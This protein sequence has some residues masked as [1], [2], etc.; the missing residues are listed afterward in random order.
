MLRLTHTQQTLMK[1]PPSVIHDLNL[2]AFASACRF[3]FP[4]DEQSGEERR[5]CE[6]S[7]D[8][9]PAP[10]ATFPSAAAS[11][12]LPTSLCPSRPH[13]VP[14][15]ATPSSSPPQTAELLCQAAKMLGHSMENI[16]KEKH[17]LSLTTKLW[18]FSKIK[19]ERA[20]EKMVMIPF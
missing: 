17:V 8:R 2:N 18:S 6:I 1:F 10:A 19:R 14:A 4:T 13:Q 5:S 16:R 9:Y 20:N 11:A 15:K 12:P 3:G 7:V